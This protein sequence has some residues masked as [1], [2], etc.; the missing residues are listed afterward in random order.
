MTDKPSMV[1]T[2]LGSCVSV[3]MFSRSM[4][5]GAICHG[6]LP[7]CGE[8]SC[9]ACDDLLKYVEC[10]IKHIVDRITKRGITTSQ[11]EVKMFGGGNVLASN[12]TRKATVGQQNIEAALETLDALNIRLQSADVG[13]TH[14]RKVIFYPHTGE[15]LM[16]RLKNSNYM[17]DSSRIA[18]VGNP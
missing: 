3:T 5:Y 15:I 12:G 7:N 10:S 1:S 6:L 18:A 17:E 8:K 14:G 2:V 16:K 9:G 11:L 4:G 13:G